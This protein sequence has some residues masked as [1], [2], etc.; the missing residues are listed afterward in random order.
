MNKL[1][2]IGDVID[3]IIVV[4]QG[5][6]RTNTDT[7]ATIVQTLGGS[8]SNVASWAARQGADVTFV[9]CVSSKD[10]ERVT[11]EFER[12]GVKCDLQRSE[13]NTGS[14]VVIVESQNRTMLT[15]R[16]ANQDLNFDDLTQHKLSSYRY[17]HLSG[18]SIFNKTVEQVQSLITKVHDSG[19]FMV[20]DPG[21]TGFI[22][23]Y[24]ISKFKAAIL[25][26]DLLLPNE[27]EFQVLGSIVKTTLVTKA[28]A[29]VDLYVDGVLVES[30]SAPVV[31]S[32]DPTGA[33]DSFAGG[34]LAALVNGVEMRN[35]ITAG[36]NC[37][38]MAVTTLG[39]RP[40]L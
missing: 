1:L 6:P 13:L 7:A 16:G 24:G 2:V 27:E 25:G 18:Y 33:G 8:A 34:A 5:E 22:N 19:A 20:V 31:D 32:I 40:K 10:V 23:D 14:L 30:F 37:A 12:Y 38:A 15:D 39:A 9:G 36:I 17:V 26:V 35:A 28:S 21:S 29:G 4:P 11:K 3:D